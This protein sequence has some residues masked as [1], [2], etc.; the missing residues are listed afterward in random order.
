[1]P[2]NGLIF[3][4]K[5]PPHNGHLNFINNALAEVSGQLYLLLFDHP[6]LGG[7]PTPE[8]ARLIKEIINNERLVVIECY[9][10]PK[11]DGSP[12]SLKALEAYTKA[13]LPQ[14]VTIAKVFCNEAYG[15]AAAEQ[16]NAQWVMLDPE[17]RAFPISATEIRNNPQA[18]RQFLH[19]LVAASLFGETGIHHFG[20]E[21]KTRWL[22][23]LGDSEISTRVH[24]NIIQTYLGFALSA[25]QA[26]NIWSKMVELYKSRE[27]TID[28]A[29]RQLHEIVRDM[30]V[31][32]G[33]Q[34]VKERMRD[35][36]DARRGIIINQLYDKAAPYLEGEV[37]DIGGGGGR[38]AMHLQKRIRE[39]GQKSQFT[40]MELA[41]FRRGEGLAV[42][43]VTF[44]NAGKLPDKSYV[45]A[46]A[47][48]CHH[49]FTDPGKVISTISR[50]TQKNLV[51]IEPIPDDDS[52]A[53]EDVVWA[54]DY[55]T[56]RHLGGNP[57]IPM[58]GGYRTE[59]GWVERLSREGWKLQ[60]M[61]K[62]G[63][64]DQLTLGD[65]AHSMMIFS[66]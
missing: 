30:R 44:D 10:S 36:A 15:K 3:G 28:D 33:V 34:T 39:R 25:A 18:H 58:P 64:G 52:I 9:N 42:N 24:N 57:H 63:K 31:E 11:A 59:A 40:L 1:M 17:R 23:I 56:N 4:K 53:A 49:H 61:H 21:I 46:V 16:F 35:M 29:D 5:N 48:C 14:N 66:R 50:V 26:E 32:G 65:V 62:L 37:L 41:D 8:R 60:E 45:T 47:S 22:R 55:I 51:M 43:L 13:H 6:E 54:V 2:S 7:I 27:L 38:I 19:P 12:E 20:E